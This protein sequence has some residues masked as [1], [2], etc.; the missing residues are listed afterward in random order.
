M[1]SLAPYRTCYLMIA[2]AQVELTPEQ[3]EIADDLLNKMVDEHFL[4]VEGAR[5]PLPSTLPG[6]RALALRLTGQL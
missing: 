1:L 6:R 3:V 4:V 5:F 2:P